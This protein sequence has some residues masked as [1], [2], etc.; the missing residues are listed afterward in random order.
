MSELNKKVASATKWSGV[1]E[2]AAR[3][4][5]PISSMVLARILT[6]DAFGVVATLSMIITFAELFTDA[7]FQKYIVQHEFLNDKDR[8]ESINVAFWSNFVFSLVIWFVI[9]LYAE[10]LAVL[11]G[12]PGLGNVLAVAC[13]SIP[14]ASFSSI[15]MAIYRRELNFKTLFKIR[16]V[17]V[18][19]PLFVTIPLALGLRSYWA[20]VF[21]TII[22]NIAN[23]L[24]L[25]YYS[26]WKPRFYYSLSKLRDM[27]NFTVW[28]LIE[29]ISIWLT[30]YV[31]VFIVGTML[32]QYYLGI[33]KTSATLVGQIMGLITAAT[34]PVLFSSLSRL[35]EDKTEFEK[36]FFKFQKIVS[37]FI[38]PLGIG[39]YCFSDLIT[40]TLLG[41]QWIEASGFVG[42][43]GLTSAFTIV[44]SHYA[45]EVYRSMGRPKLSVI[46]QW[47]HIIV[48]WP[49]V[50]IAAN[51]GFETLY[52][53]RSLVRIEL[54]V[55]NVAFLV[56]CL[57]F[58]LFKMIK[59]ISPSC[60]SSL[61][62]VFI[63]NCMLRDNASLFLQIVSIFICA[64]VYVLVLL[65]FPTERYIV[66][67]WI[68][69]M[70]SNFFK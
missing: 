46:V 37:I 60:L 2:I 20:L 4:V 62:I 70:S 32:S 57:D 38:F 44:L 54:I 15:Q 47:L 22:Q 28:S 41:N 25:S 12:N 42:L 45:S 49:A 55:V 34:T 23:A 19:I 3:L 61:M 7:G 68:S 31:D 52:I 58:S 43:W 40:V 30:D 18:A 26:K 10:P 13:I 35:Q 29:A 14:L 16:I 6:P 36:L 21:G 50:L 17:S 56:F 65:C 53:T 5:A 48:L 33:Y 27:L 63:S 9:I 67:D 8:E 69:K 64:I 11:V 24:L 66:K 51:Y 39:I 59:N 1:T